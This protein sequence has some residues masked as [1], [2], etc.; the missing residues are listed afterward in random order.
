MFG[1]LLHRL[2]H[3]LYGPEPAWFQCIKAIL[4]N[5]AVWANNE[6]A[7][8]RKFDYK[9]SDF[10]QWRVPN[11]LW[12]FRLYNFI[13]DRLLPK[14][15]EY[16]QEKWCKNHEWEYDG[17]IEDKVYSWQTCKICGKYVQHD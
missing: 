2:G 11:C 14:L 7:Y 4:W 16:G 15:V 1:K 10:S 17:Y 13:K 9:K 6:D 8:A 5:I 12:Y 3:S